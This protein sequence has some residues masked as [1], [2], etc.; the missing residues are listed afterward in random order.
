MPG[1]YWE[2]VGKIQ[3]PHQVTSCQ[4]GAGWEIWELRDDGLYLILFRPATDCVL[5]A[6]SRSER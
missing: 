1:K 2:I 4:G 3:L 6:V 5:P